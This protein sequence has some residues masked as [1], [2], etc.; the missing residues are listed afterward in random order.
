MPY[1]LIGDDSGTKGQ[2]RFVVMGGLVGR[3]ALWARFADAWRA[4][5]DESPAISH[6]K[7]HD[8]AKFAGPFRGFKDDQRNAKLERLAALINDY[9]VDELYVAVDVAAWESY[10]PAPEKTKRKA[11]ESSRLRRLSAVTH[12]PYYY[13]YNTFISAATI[14]LWEKGEREPFEFIVDEHPS[15]GPR[16]KEWY[17]VA[18]ACMRQPIRDI[19]P[20]EPLPRNDHDFLP[21]QAADM[22]AGL[23]RD[24]RVGSAREF[25]WVFDHL[26]NMR[27]SQR[28][29]IAGAA[30][31][32][33][34]KRRGD[35]A[36]ARGE[37]FTIDAM[38]QQAILEGA[39]LPKSGETWDD[40]KR[41]VKKR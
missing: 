6:F 7:M 36:R 37:V 35:A 4:A 38:I 28:C 26:P 33:E 25:S 34:V 15:L 14:D 12:T 13:A 3:A 20:T 1:Q 41:R 21:L 30:W 22:I 29:L 19:M 11:G 17:P 8:A 27:R 39:P 40:A 5:L 16:T 32:A 23:E 24:A 9:P 2:G 31:F 18:R 10:H